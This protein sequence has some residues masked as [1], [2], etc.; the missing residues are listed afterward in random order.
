MSFSL[1]TTKTLDEEVNI[2]TSTTS[3]TPSPG[4]EDGDPQPEIPQSDDSVQFIFV[5]LAVFITVIFLSAMVYLMARTKRKMITRIYNRVRSSSDYTMLEPSDV[6]HDEDNED[7]PN[8]CLLAGKL[9]IENRYDSYS[10]HSYNC[11][12]RELYT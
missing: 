5:P 6:E 1:P 3:T 4:M 7:D 11:S 10:I 2:S 8:E 12:Q 9:Q